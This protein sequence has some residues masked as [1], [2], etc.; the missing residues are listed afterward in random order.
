[1]VGELALRK[2]LRSTSVFALP[3]SMTKRV[4]LLKIDPMFVVALA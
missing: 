3:S 2:E 1:M 4:L